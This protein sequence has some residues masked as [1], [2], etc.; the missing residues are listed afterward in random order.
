MKSKAV[1]RYLVFLI[2]AVMAMDFMIVLTSIA[3]FWA[4]VRKYHIFNSDTVLDWWRSEVVRCCILCVRLYTIF[5][6]TTS[7]FMG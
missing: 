7:R 6:W 5:Y 1:S 3:G 4:Y 2:G